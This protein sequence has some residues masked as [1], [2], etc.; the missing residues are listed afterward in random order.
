[1]SGVM[2]CLG[3]TWINELVPDNKRGR[4][5]AIYTTVFTISQLLGPSIIALYGVA[6]KTPILISVLLHIISIVLFL[7]MD[8]KIGDK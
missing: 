8:Q 4:I 6:D 3:E 1:A 7:M 2:I 5:L